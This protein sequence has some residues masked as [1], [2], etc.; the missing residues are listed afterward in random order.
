MQLTSYN[1]HP[2]TTEWKEGKKSTCTQNISATK[3][4]VHCYIVCMA[5]ACHQL[6]VFSNSIPKSWLHINYV[7]WKRISEFYVS[8]AS[9]SGF[10]F[11]PSLNIFSCIYVVVERDGRSYGVIF[12]VC[13]RYH[14]EKKFVL[15]ICEL[16]FHQMINI[17]SFQLK[18]FNYY[19]CN[20]L[21]LPRFPLSVVSA[22]WYG[23]VNN[24]S[25]STETNGYPYDE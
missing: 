18:S 14:V 21:Q 6:Y 16:W 11:A 20:T 22:L 17:K 13:A 10:F 12:C 4:I 19:C 25:T 2:F 23:A 1:R 3:F 9:V 8:F 24:N 7:G 15:F 5:A